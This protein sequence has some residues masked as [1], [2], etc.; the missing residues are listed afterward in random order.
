MTRCYEFYCAI[1]VNP[2]FCEEK[3]DRTVYYIQEYIKFMQNKGVKFDKSPEDKELFQRHQDEFGSE[4]AITQPIDMSKTEQLQHVAL[5]ECSQCHM[6]SQET[7]EYKGKTLCPSCLEDAGYKPDRK[8]VEL[9]TVSATIIKPKE[10]WEHRKAQ[11]QVPVSKMEEAVLVKLE[12]KGV[13]PEVQK[14]FCLQHTRPDYY[15]PQQNLAI[16][17][18]GPVHV[19]R[20]DRDEALRELL[21]K[22]HN[23]RVVTILYVGS[24]EATEDNIVQQIIEKLLI[25]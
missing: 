10:S 14:E 8:P 7:T 17:L 15:F 12:Q 3:S 22:R 25:I 18:D 16:Y 5:V 4:R 19:G 6:G 24:S 21:I 23:V 11:M 2:A 9:A 20:E 1:L 13:H